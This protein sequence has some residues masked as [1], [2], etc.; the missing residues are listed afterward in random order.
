MIPVMTVLG[1][2]LSTL[3]SGQLILE[4]LFNID[5]VGQFAFDA[6]Q[7]RDYPVIQA[8]VLVTAAFLV[9]INLLVDLSYA[10]L[11]PRIRYS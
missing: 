3:I 2:T 10:W 1:L 5:G 11:D 8:F 9:F 7:D 4:I 6:I